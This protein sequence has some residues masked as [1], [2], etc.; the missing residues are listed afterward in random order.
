MG[1]G[2]DDKTKQPKKKVTDTARLPPS[3]LLGLMLKHGSTPVIEGMEAEGQQELVRANG[4]SLP[5]EG[6]THPCFAKMGIVF[7]ESLDGVFREAA[8]PPGWTIR[9]RSDHAM[10]SDLLDAKGRKRASIFYKAAFYDRRATMHPCTR[11]TTE[12]E[13]QGEFGKAGESHRGY[14]L[15]NATGTELFSTK[16]LRREGD[17]RTF[18]KTEDLRKETEAWIVEH[19]PE[20]RDPAAYWD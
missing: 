14:V 16:T 12:V 9:A 3:A 18:L 10:W 11:Y 1:R 13:Y 19:F 17:D 2:T 20:Y 4:A 5:V 7:G 6:S 15:D 8:V